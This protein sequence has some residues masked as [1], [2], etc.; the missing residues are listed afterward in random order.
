MTAAW[1]ATAARSGSCTR[2]T[3]LWPRRS[4]TRPP[5]PREVRADRAAPRGGAALRAALGLP[6]LLLRGR[7][8][9]PLPPRLARRGAAP[10]AARR[11]GPRDRRGP[12]RGRVLQ[13]IRAAVAA[14]RPT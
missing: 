1:A 12:D 14:L 3:K 4:S 10:L 7:G 8:A 11:A 13:G 9:R 5:G 6:R 2:A